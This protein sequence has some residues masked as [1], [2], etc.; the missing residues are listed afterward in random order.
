MKYLELFEA[1]KQKNI[2]IEDVVKC[3]E[4]GGVIFTKIVENLPSHDDIEKP[5][6][7]VSVDDLIGLTPDQINKKYLKYKQKYLMTK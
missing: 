7:P 3:I 6:R 1:F 5:L 4:S 2:E